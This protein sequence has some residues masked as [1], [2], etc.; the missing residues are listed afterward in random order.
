VHIVKKQSH[1]VRCL[2][3]CDVSGSMCGVDSISPMDAAVSLSMLLAESA[4]PDT[5]LYG[6]IVTFETEP[7]LVQLPMR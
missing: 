7:K 5:P 3:V 4:D 6:R 1:K 2:P